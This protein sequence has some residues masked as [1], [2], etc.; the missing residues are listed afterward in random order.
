MRGLDLNVLA[1]PRPTTTEAWSYL[2]TSRAQAN[3]VWNEIASMSVDHKGFA[4]SE[5][6]ARKMSSFHRLTRRGMGVKILFF[7]TLLT[8]ILPAI[9]IAPTAVLLGYLYIVKP[10][11]IQRF[12]EWG[13]GH[14]LHQMVYILEYF[15]GMRVRTFGFDGKFKRKCLFIM[16]HRTHLDWMFFWAVVERQGDL[17]GW[18]AVTKSDM[19]KYPFV[20][21]A[22]QYMNN[23]FVSRKWENDEHELEQ[24]LKFYNSVNGPLQL[25]LFPE[26]TDFNAKSKGKSDQYADKNGLPRYEYCLHPHS[27]GFVHLVQSLRKE[28]LEAVYDITIGFPDALPKTEFHF[29]KGVIPSEI[30]Y[31]IKEY[32]IDSLPSENEALV[33]WCAQRWAEKEERLKQFYQNREFSETSEPGDK[34]ARPHEVI[35]HHNMFNVFFAPLFYIAIAVFTG[36]LAYTCHYVIYYGVLTICW[37]VYHLALREGLDYATMDM[38]YKRKSAA[39]V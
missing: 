22:V 28:G 6:D 27:T 1:K 8:I 24:K 20:G 13:C 2:T 26:G 25:L 10:R 15:L 31:Y 30:H 17:S 19:K 14:W 38:Y 3:F 21:V 7:Y 9:Y 33:S 11:N 39:I 5:Q 37:S 34:Q 32:N 18:K 16:N 23:I 4:L 36:Y 12:L 35:V 29:L